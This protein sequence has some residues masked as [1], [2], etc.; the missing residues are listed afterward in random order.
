MSEASDQDT[1]QFLRTFKEA[2]TDNGLNIWPTEK[3]K[4][5]LF[6]SGFTK[7]D[8]EE[9]ILSLKVRDYESGPFADN[10]DHRPDGEVWVFTKEYEGFEL[11]I[12]IKLRDG[13]IIAECLSA[14]EAEF[15][16]K[17]PKKDRR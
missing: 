6:E 11:Y 16:M 3:N 1:E 12:K 8:V 15:E 7:E 13:Q 4:D 17:K 14:H 2:V 10:K 9:I 5:F